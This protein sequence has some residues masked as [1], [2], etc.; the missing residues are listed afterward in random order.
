MDLPWIEED[1]SNFSS[2]EQKAKLDKWLKS[3]REKGFMLNQAPLMRCTLIK[4]DRDKYRFIWS[5]YHI[6]MDGW[7]N[8]ILL[9]E[10]VAIYEALN[11]RNPIELEPPQPYRNYIVWL[12][13]QDI[14]QAEKYWQS[15]Y[16]SIIS[17]NRFRKP[18]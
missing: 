16:Q 18:R 9:R 3:D 1:W 4:L 5:H 10:V 11:Q 13:E 14:N 2:L 8:G 12:Q 17:I 7:C 15:S 6:L